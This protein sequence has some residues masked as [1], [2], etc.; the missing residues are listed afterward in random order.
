M[1]N[2]R[3]QFASN[4]C[5]YG[6]ESTSPRTYPYPMPNASLNRTM[7]VYGADLDKSPTG[8]GTTC[9]AGSCFVRYATLGTAPNRTFVVS[10]V[11]VP[12]WSAPGS[13]FTFQ[14]ILYESGEFVYQY[15]ASSNT[16]GG[17][18]EVGWQL[19]TSD[20]RVTQR[21]IPANGTAIRYFI[22]RPQTICIPPGQVLSA[23]SGELDIEGGSTVN[24]AAITGSGNALL[25]SGARSPWTPT[26]AA[27][28]PASF[29]VFSGSANANSTNVPGGTYA[30]VAANTAGFTFL[31]GT[32]FITNL[33]VNASSITLG[34][35]DYFISNLSLPDN[36]TITVSPA[37][38]V[39]LFLRG[40][41]ERDGVSIN[42]GGN[43]ANLQI[44]LYGGG[45]ID[46]GDAAVSPPSSTRRAEAPSNSTTR[47][48]SKAQ[49]SHGPA[50]STSAR[51]LRSPTPPRPSRRLRVSRRAQ[52]PAR[53][54]S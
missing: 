44:F 9:P 2:G 31:G 53:Q 32:Y 22:A 51:T 1:T 29:P 39:R 27:L 50:R 30:S 43:P 48:S 23:A 13:T 47:R 4:F 34:P 11:N 14:V 52:G 10:W 33:N 6:T 25:S 42:A 17:S 19:S 41:E 21:G 24:G 16:S 5:G 45:D 3:L 12:E 49:S 38:P 36:V 37:G 46:F 20:F 8:T 28:N 15:G 7:R 18:A 40:L 54:R 26:A 35:G